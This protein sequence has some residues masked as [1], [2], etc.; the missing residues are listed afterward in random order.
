[1]SSIIYTEPDYSLSEGAGNVIVAT[2]FNVERN[3]I[4]GDNIR[5]SEYSGIKLD[6]TTLT[7]CGENTIYDNVIQG[8]QRIR[9]I[10]ALNNNDSALTIR[11]G[12]KLTIASNS[13]INYSLVE[14]GG[15]NNSIK[16]SFIP[17]YLAHKTLNNSSKI[18]FIY[19]KP[20]LKVRYIYE[21]R[22]F[23]EKKN[24]SKEDKREIEFEVKL[25]EKLIIEKLFGKSK[26]QGGLLELLILLMIILASLYIGLNLK[27]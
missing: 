11:S 20:T 12:G 17:I 23:L 27:Y 7:L 9:S 2:A 13:A 4:T 18:I 19:S 22:K 25:I 14:L 3:I 5:A 15:D 6:T 26:N 1:M 8:T 16:E 21:F 24:V 10:V